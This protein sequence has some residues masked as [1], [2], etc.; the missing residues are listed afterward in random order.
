MEF[1][2]KRLNKSDKSRLEEAITLYQFPSHEAIP[3]LFIFATFDSIAG[4]SLGRTNHLDR[5]ITQ[6]TGPQVQ[7]ARHVSGAIIRVASGTQS[8]V[9]TITLAS[10]ELQFDRE[11]ACPSDI[12]NEIYRR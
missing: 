11:S 6:L 4:N 8:R 12:Q 5:E 9:S 10:R 2:F 3:I 7:P 1:L